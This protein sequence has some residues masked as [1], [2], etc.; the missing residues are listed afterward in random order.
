MLA[1]LTM[2]DFEMRDAVIPELIKKGFKQVDGTWK[3]FTGL[4][5]GTNKSNDSFYYNGLDIYIS[6]T[7]IFE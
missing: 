7:E 4:I 3:D 2:R 5:S 1:R 6:W